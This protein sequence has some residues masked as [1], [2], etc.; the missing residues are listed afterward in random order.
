VK[1]ILLPA[2]I[3]AVLVWTVLIGGILLL[4]WPWPA[5]SRAESKYHALIAAASRAAQDGRYARAANAARTAMETGAELDAHLAESERLRGLVKRDPDV[6]PPF[7]VTAKV[8]L[9]GY[10]FRAQ[11]P[12]DAEARYREALATLADHPGGA[13]LRADAAHGLAAMYAALCPT[14]TLSCPEPAAPVE[15]PSAP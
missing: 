4:T 9:A 10:L 11:H 2:A 5:Y 3:G 6:Q 13:A 15:P 7:E 14:D 1:K 8:A 12:A